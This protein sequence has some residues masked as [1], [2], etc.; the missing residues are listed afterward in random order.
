MHI[1]CITRLETVG[2]VPASPATC[3][4]HTDEKPAGSSTG[5]PAGAAMQAMHMQRLAPGIPRAQATR[6]QNAEIPALVIHPTPVTENG[7]Q[8]WVADAVGFRLDSSSGE[9]Q[10]VAQGPTPTS[11][12]P[13]W[14]T[15]SIFQPFWQLCASILGGGIWG[16]SSPPPPQFHPAPSNHP[17]HTLTPAAAKTH[18][19]PSRIKR[20]RAVHVGLPAAGRTPHRPGP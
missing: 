15:A 9:A 1:Y 2:S 3:R 17:S 5:A 7:L 10:K 4:L 16:Y 11:T 18:M 12:S 19:Q 14:T 8:F 6:E 13:A 20:S